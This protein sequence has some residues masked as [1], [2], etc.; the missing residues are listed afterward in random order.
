MMPLGGHEVKNHGAGIACPGGRGF[1]LIETL[2]AVTLLAVSLTVILQLFSGGLR[3]AALSRDYNRG[4]FHARAVLE[5]TLLTTPTEE[6][7][8]Q[9][10]FDDGYRWKA[11]IAY[12]EQKEEEA[13]RL[14]FE[15]LHVKVTVFWGSEEKAKHVDLETT[16]IVGKRQISR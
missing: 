13:A 10:S 2:V 15:F 7:T 12:V 11:D 16:E 3:S 1:T 4:I 8:L 9:G 14:P 6:G 5:E